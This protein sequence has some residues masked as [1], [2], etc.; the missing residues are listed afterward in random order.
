VTTTTTRLYRLGHAV[1]PAVLAAVLA[2]LAAWGRAP[3]IVGVAAMQVLLLLAFLALVDAPAAVGVLVIGTAAAVASDVVVAVDDGRVGGLA[4]VVALAFVGGLLQQLARRHRSRVTESLADTLV[5][6][7]L[8]AC[9]ACLP[10]ALQSPDGD[11]LVPAGLA[12]TGAALVV[13]RLALVARPSSPSSAVL[14]SL[15]AGTLTTAGL[16]ADHGTS[17]ERLL[18]GLAVAASATLVDVVTA[19]AAGDVLN[20]PRDR[21]RLASLRP[22]TQLL[23]F[24]VVA[25]VLLLAARLLDRA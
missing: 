13:G 15:V 14:A 12:G 20:G 3:L 19:L 4:G 23:P 18:L 11:W 5:V 21:R 9:A 17:R 1:T 25:P 16:A 22:V 6:V 2:G 24:A 10:A 7:V 8:V